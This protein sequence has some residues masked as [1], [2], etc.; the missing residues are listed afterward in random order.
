MLLVARRSL[1]FKV[2]GFIALLN[3]P[4]AVTLLSQGLSEPSPVNVFPT[5]H[6]AVMSYHYT[7]T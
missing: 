6:I 1:F 7:V 4:V 5:F 3:Q 2:Y